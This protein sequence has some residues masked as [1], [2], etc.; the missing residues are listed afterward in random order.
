[1]VLS[2]SKENGKK[3]AYLIKDQL[4]ISYYTDYHVIY[5][6]TISIDN[7]EIKNILNILASNK[8]FKNYMKK[9]VEQ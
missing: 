1:M 4:T 8:E 6:A 3:E 2:Q 7:A 9:L 5:S